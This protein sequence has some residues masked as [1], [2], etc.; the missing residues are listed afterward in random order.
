[1]ITAEVKWVAKFT[2]SEW[3]RS[4]SMEWT[5]HGHRGLDSSVI[6]VM[7]SKKVAMIARDNRN[8]Y[9]HGESSQWLR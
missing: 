9:G 6:M 4:M 2:L 8:N 7:E 3:P 1:M 5:L